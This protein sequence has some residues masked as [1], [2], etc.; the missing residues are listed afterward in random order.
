MVVY[1][2][3]QK[4]EDPIYLTIFTLNLRSAVVRA[5][6]DDGNLMNKRVRSLFGHQPHET[7]ELFRLWHSANGQTLLLVQSVIPP[8]TTVWALNDVLGAPF[9]RDVRP[10]WDTLVP[11]QWY[12]FDVLASISK[13]Y[14]GH[15]TM[16]RRDDERLM[17]LQQKGLQ[18]GFIV[19]D[20]SVRWQ[21]PAPHAGVKGRRQ[22]ISIAPAHG[23]GTVCV[24]DVAAFCEILQSGI[25]RSKALGLGLIVLPQLYL[26]QELQ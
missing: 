5:S 18:H 16:L 8:D 25:G 4:H 23:I 9:Q 11:Q 6:L 19:T 15:E 1:N 2:K 21:S 3:I 24:Q 7:R 14:N 26:P 13:R 12:S 10:L 22:Q 20:Q 17:W